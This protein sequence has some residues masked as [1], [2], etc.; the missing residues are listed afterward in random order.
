M[1]TLSSTSTDAEVWASYDDN[2]SYREDA[3]VSKALAFA[4]A[5]RI[6]LRRLP[7]SFSKAG[8]STTISAAQLQAELKDAEDYADA[9]DT[10]SS[11]KQRV[12]HYGVGGRI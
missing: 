12:E 4:T 8:V 1:S 9:N 7:T 11:A 6:L 3:S 2:A 5:V 10:S